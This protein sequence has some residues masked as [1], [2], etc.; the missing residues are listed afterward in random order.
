MT[1]KVL[2]VDNG[3][4]LFRKNPSGP[5]VIN[6]RRDIKLLFGSLLQ[7]GRQAGWI[8]Y[9]LQT[10]SGMRVRMAER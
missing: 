1:G 2:P 6:E 10:F 3:D 9:F 7:I 5:G 8:V 4:P